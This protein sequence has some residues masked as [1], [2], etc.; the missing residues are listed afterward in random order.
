MEEIYIVKLKGLP[1]PNATTST[2]SGLHCYP[3]TRLPDDRKTTFYLTTDLTAE[4][5]RGLSYL[6][7]F[8]GFT[9]LCLS[10]T[11]LCFHDNPWLLEPPLGITLWCAITFIIL[12]LFGLLAAHQRTCNLSRSIVYVRVYFFLIIVAISVTLTFVI[13]FI[14]GKF[15]ISRYLYDGF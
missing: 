3:T 8:L 2:P 14:L 5:V 1:P 4:A 15:S 12:G 13:L 11:N 9:I 10:I 7:I 6:H